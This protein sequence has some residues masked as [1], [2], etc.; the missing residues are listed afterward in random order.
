MRATPGVVSR[1]V[2]DTSTLISAALR[3]GSAPWQALT[4]ALRFCEVCASRRTLDELRDVASRAKFDRY[5]ASDER[6]KFVRE[7]ELGVRLF[8]VRE[9]EQ[10]TW[11]P[12]CGD[13]SDQ[14]FLELALE[15]E[16]ETIVSSDEDLLVLDPW[17]SIRIVSPSAFAEQMGDRR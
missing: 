1:V 14:K 2:F 4:L 16:A 10:A 12:L 6:L 3:Q 15:A 11:G 7:L 13:A 5:L 9:G 17:N 8:D